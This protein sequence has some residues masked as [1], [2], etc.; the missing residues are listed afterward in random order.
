MNK[1]QHQLV[2]I[3]RDL[4]L[5]PGD[6]RTRGQHRFWHT[7]LMSPR[8]CTTKH[9]TMTQLKLF[10]LV[11]VGNLLL[12][13]SPELLYGAAWP[14]LWCLVGGSILPTSVNSFNCV[15]V[16]CLVVHSLGDISCVCLACLVPQNL[17][18]SAT[19]PVLHW[20]KK[21]I[22]C[23]FMCVW[24]I[25]CVL[26]FGH[27]RPTDSD[28]CLICTCLSVRNFENAIN[29]SYTHKTALYLL[30]LPV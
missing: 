24:F 7:Q 12:E 16:K 13:V 9:F 30:L 21:K 28:C 3:D 15:I 4:Y 10:T 18:Q 19:T 6:S 25:D 20:K 29:K 5:R 14:Q 11:G 26:R 23:G 27:E 1:I 22:Q 8:L 17:K 2:G